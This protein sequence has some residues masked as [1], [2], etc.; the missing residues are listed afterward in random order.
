LGGCAEWRRVGLVVVVV[1][2]AC[3]CVGEKF[4][5]DQFWVVEVDVA[6]V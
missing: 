5:A 2:E 6:V 3:T 1:L 4:V